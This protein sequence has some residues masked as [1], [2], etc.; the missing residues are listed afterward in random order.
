MAYNLLIERFLP[1]IRADLTQDRIAPWQ[2]AE[3]ENPVVA[4]AAPRPDFNGV[5]I[6]F[7]IGLLQTAY[8]PKNA[9]LWFKRFEQPPAPEEL[10]QAFEHYRHAFDLNGD[11]PRFMQDLDPLAEQKP[12]PVTA[13][14]IDTAGS[15]T[16]FVK[17]LPDQ[18]FSP[19]LAAM[20]LFALQT[21]AP[22]GGVGHRTSI[23]GGGP[24]TTLV[25]SSPVESRKPIPLWQT[26]WLNVLVESEFHSR[27]NRDEDI[28]PWLAPTRTSEKS[29]KTPVTAP[30]DVHPLQMFWG[31][32]RR[33]RLD[34][35][36]VGSGECGLSGEPC[37]LL[38]KQY[39]TRN[40]GINYGGAWEHSLNPHNRETSEIIP[41]HPRGSIHYRH[42][43]GLVQEPKKKKGEKQR[44]PARTVQRFW[45]EHLP[46]EGFQ[47]R[48]WAFGYDMDNM[49]PR[50]WYEGTMPLFHLDDP[51][52]RERFEATV[53]NLIR[54]AG[55]FLGNLRSCLKDAWFDPE[56]PRRNNAD[57][58]FLDAAFWPDTENGFYNLL[59]ALHAEP[60]N[61]TVRKQ[62]FLDWHRL[63]HRYTQDTFH[64]YANT[65]Q[66][67][68]QNP[69][70]IARAYRNL[71]RF[72]HKKEI[73]TLLDMPLKQPKTI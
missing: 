21:N 16:H 71:K 22:S 7:L 58:G 37:E 12:I 25:V 4:L 14:L 27:N 65:G 31:M 73:K 66:I 35:E 33:I 26:L 51:A 10:Q 40:Y 43:L 59:N 42:W 9:P 48:L 28:F 47:F 39:R 41:M 29:S 36:N 5:L 56:D 20:A 64:R 72:N 46:D 23:R 70:R 19:A 1:V 18:G 50:C 54:A 62:A 52:Q 63:L 32:P 30:D 69:K 3:T 11:G 60:G 57:M 67:T 53:E 44:V 45:R 61:E 8:A 2:I 13:L 55:E 34:F 24:L 17:N 68:E 15:E 6:Q 49:K 38:V